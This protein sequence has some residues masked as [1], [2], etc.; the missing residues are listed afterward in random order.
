MEVPTACKSSWYH[1]ECPAHA[2][3]LHRGSV[4]VGLWLTMELLQAAE[5]VENLP[6]MEEAWVR[7]LSQKSPWRRKGQHTPIF[8]PGEFHG[9][10]SLMGYSPR[11]CKES[12]TVEQY[13]T[14]EL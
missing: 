3:Q 13:S 14:G 6:A 10:K 11:G 8:L 12:D 2:H 1:T 9:Q 7:S 4:S 5:T